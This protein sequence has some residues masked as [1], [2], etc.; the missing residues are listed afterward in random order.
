MF[1]KIESAEVA[2]ALFSLG[3]FYS[4]ETINKKT[5]YCFKHSPEL[6]SVI[7]NKF[8]DARLIVDDYMRF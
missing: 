3:F 2:K 1:V 7:M 6:A 8:A 4:T 5:F